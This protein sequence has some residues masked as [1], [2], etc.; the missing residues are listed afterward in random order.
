M[1]LKCVIL[2]TNFETS[3]SVKDLRPL[4]PFNLQFWWLEVAWFT[5]IVFFQT[6]MTK[7]NFKKSI[8][9]S[10]QWRHRY[11]I[12]K[13]GHHTNVTRFFNFEPLLI[14]TS[15]YAGFVF[16]KTPLCFRVRVRVRIEIRVRV[17]GNTFKYVLGQMFIRASALDPY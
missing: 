7:L 14:K 3:L 8:V 10:F 9:T 11:Y 4:R 17:S 1:C 16:P 15:G 5:Q 12:T 13:E 6:I 2:I